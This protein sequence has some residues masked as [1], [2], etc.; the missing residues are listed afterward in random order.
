MGF[1][2]INPCPQ[3]HG[4]KKFYEVDQSPLKLFK[5]G[6]YTKVPLMAGACANDGTLVLSTAY[7]QN[8]VPLGL[9]TDEHFLKY[10]I[11]EYMTDIVDMDAAFAFTH[12][13]QKD[14]F[15]DNEMGNFDLMTR[16]LTDV[17]SKLENYQKKL[18]F[19]ILL[20]RW[21]DVTESS[22]VSH[23]RGQLT[24]CQFLR[25]LFGKRRAK[26]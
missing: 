5:S 6:N 22:R 12:D 10:G 9:D 7:S 14:Y 19:M 24:I 26:S 4:K 1:G 8:L 13:I 23:G 11:I 25:L 21:H 20:V 2:G 3:S 15:K 16:G 18:N 17:N